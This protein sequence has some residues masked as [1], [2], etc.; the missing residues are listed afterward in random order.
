MHYKR[1]IFFCTNLRDD[2]ACCEDHDAR[3]MRDYVK[4]RV[5]A[6]GLIGP[7]GI[8]VNSAG[9]L[10]RCAEGPTVV[11]Y[12]EGVWYTYRDERDLDEIIEEHLRHGR[13]VERLMML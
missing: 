1:H 13:V 11:V 5:K 8:R 2:R 4:D 7:G 9:C 12:P 6:L 10:G 3:R